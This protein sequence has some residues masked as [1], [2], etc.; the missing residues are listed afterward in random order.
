MARGDRIEAG[1]TPAVQGPSRDSVV[2]W[3]AAVPPAF[4]LAI[5]AWPRQCRVAESG[6]RVRG[7]SA[8][9]VQPPF[10]LLEG[11]DERGVASGIAHHVLK[12]LRVAPGRIGGVGN[13]LG[14]DVDLDVGFH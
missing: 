11:L 13:R 14:S 7:G 2:S 12:R 10:G 8:C 4:P 5:W 1:E 9:G 6:S 3:P